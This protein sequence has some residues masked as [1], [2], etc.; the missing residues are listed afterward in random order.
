MKGKV[1]GRRTYML[2]KGTSARSTGVWDGVQ[3]TDLDILWI[4]GFQ[5]PR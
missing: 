1:N 2:Y 5:I 4:G 3:D